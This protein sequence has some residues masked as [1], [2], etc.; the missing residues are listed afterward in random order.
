MKMYEVDTFL[1]ECV[2][3]RSEGRKQRQEDGY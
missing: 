1:K 3:K 2:G